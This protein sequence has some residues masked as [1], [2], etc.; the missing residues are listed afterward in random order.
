MLQNTALHSVTCFISINSFVKYGV[1]SDKSILFIHCEMVPRQNSF[2]FSYFFCLNGWS[3]WRTCNGIRRLVSVGH[4]HIH[5]TSVLMS[6]KSLL[7]KNFNGIARLTHL[8]SIIFRQHS[9]SKG[10]LKEV[11]QEF[12]AFIECFNLTLSKQVIS[13][14]FSRCVGAQ[15]KQIWSC[16]FFLMF[17]SSSVS[18]MLLKVGDFDFSLVFQ[19]LDAFQKNL[20]LPCMGYLN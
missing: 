9:K 17:Y 13:N 10:V 1:T 2:S 5:R 16:I 4:L 7:H 6:T 12:S 20:T 11:L 19:Y 15:A 14:I 18:F 3:F 8:Q